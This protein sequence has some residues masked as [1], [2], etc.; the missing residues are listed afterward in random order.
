MTI[1]ACGRPG[2][3]ARSRGSDPLPGRPAGVPEMPLRAA[4]G[5]RPWRRTR[6]AGE[7][8]RETAL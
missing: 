1:P 7:R 3:A 2:S 8:E 6:M 4:Q 5:A